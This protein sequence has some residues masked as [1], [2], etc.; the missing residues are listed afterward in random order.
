MY[1]NW[2]K[3]CKKNKVLKKKIVE[4]N[5]EKDVMKRAAINYEFFA[6]DKE[7]KIQQINS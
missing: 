7:R 3:V 5:K 2:V 4:L 1:D 6:L